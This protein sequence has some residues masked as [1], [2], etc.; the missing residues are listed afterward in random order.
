MKV[1][2]SAGEAKAVHS[3]ADRNML[4][5]ADSCGKSLT[6]N[7]LPMRFKDELHYAMLHIG[8]P[9]LTLPAGCVACVFTWEGAGKLIGTLH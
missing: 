4:F 7:R 9:L 3:P 5:E 2:V 1:R 6:F 8:N